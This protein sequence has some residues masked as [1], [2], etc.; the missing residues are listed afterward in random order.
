METIV[1]MLHDW[2]FPSTVLFCGSLIG[3]FLFRVTPP[4][5]GASKPFGTMLRAG[6]ARHVARRERLD[7]LE[8]L[9]T[10]AAV[11]AASE[12]QAALQW[13]RRRMLI[14][15]LVIA[16]VILGPVYHLA[17]VNALPGW[18]YGTLAVLGLL[19]SWRRW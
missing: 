8:G 16:A 9:A 6:V 12:F 10:V 7:V 4:P 13:Q 2:R 18:L 19:H 17:P 1:A 15:G 3:D 11:Q 14:Y 5:R